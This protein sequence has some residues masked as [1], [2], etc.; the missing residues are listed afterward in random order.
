MKLVLSPHWAALDRWSH[1]M[2]M[3]ACWMQACLSLLVIGY[4]LPA[5]FNQAQDPS[6][7]ALTSP[8]EAPAN[9]L[10][11]EQEQLAKRFQR[12]EALLLKSSEIES[13]SNPTRAA[14]LQQAAQ[15]GKQAQLAEL[16]T[17]AAKSL[18]KN[19]FSQAAEDQKVSRD[20]L[21]RLL[22]LL[23]SENRQ[24]RV[25][26]ER[27]QIKNLIE[28]TDRL[29]R[30]QSALRGRTEGGSQTEKAASDQQKLAEKAGQIAEQL[31][32]KD[33]KSEED[34]SDAGKSEEGK[35]EDSESK[36]GESKDGKAKD[37]KSEDKPSEDGKPKDGEAKDSE[38]TDGKS[39]DGKSEDGKP[40]DGKPQDGKP[41]DGK[42]EDSKDSKDGKQGDDKQEPKT[43]KDKDD[44]GKPKDSDGKPSDSKPSDSKP[45]DSKPSDSKPSDSKPSDSK[46]SDSQPSES[47]P[48]QSQPGQSPSEPQPPQPPQ[49]K[50]PTERAAERVKQAQQRM[51]EAQKE[52]EKAERDGAVDK[53]RAAEQELQAAIEQLEEILRQLR[54]EEI[55]RSLAALE[56]RLRLMLQAQNKVL[57][58]TKRLQEIAGGGTD[59]QVE[60]RASN[61]A[62]DE[63]KILSEGQR[64]L[65]LLRDEGTSA[66][67]PEAMTQIIGDIQTVVDRLTKA[68]IGKLTVSIEQEIVTSLEEMV[69]ALAEVQKDKKQRKQQP[70]SP[71]QQPGGEPGE[72]PLVDQLA[73][74]RLIK[75]LQLR[76]NKRTQT[77]SEVLKD[78][79]DVV[80]QADAEDIQTQ[81]R[82]LSQRQSSIKQVTRD[83]VTGKNRQ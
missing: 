45:S 46:P 16:L 80:G 83:I 55:E 29:R 74:M 37:G 6:A 30:L 26:Q 13:A 2:N 62:G 51:Q 53:Q 9:P 72:Q 82:E 14:L 8:A 78:P 59:R 50:S 57:D 38:S 81:L 56:D 54:E 66:A 47:Q 68:D 69:A 67:F 5:Q 43:D 70:P 58:E 35:P 19:Q 21:K 34:K 11:S 77:L 20:S 36:D 18:E 44:Q 22:E 7:P 3:N 28:E 32:P 61:L 65:L 75:T 27:D 23:Q 25:R 33:A 41:Q 17:R 71:G 42:S 15:L 12:L 73:E 4:G 64:A 1:A 24:D 52:L 48:S 49:P 79:N 10:A 60:I 40:Q 76:I 39:K 31:T 63:R